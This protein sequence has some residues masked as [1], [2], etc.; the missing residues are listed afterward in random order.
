MDSQA[1][2]FLQWSAY[3]ATWSRYSGQAEGPAV[4]ARRWGGLPQWQ[5]ERAGSLSRCGLSSLRA[6]GCAAI[7]KLALGARFPVGKIPSGDSLE[8]LS[9][10]EHHRANIFGRLLAERREVP[11][12]IVALPFSQAGTLAYSN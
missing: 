3:T 9:V 4:L 6:G 7:I 12:T 11:V 5:S 1:A 2:D 8:L 10:G